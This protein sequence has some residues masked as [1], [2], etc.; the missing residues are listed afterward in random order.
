[1]IGMSLAVQVAAALPGPRLAVGLGGARL[2]D[3]EDGGA[4]HPL[5]VPWLVAVGPGLTVA[6]IVGIGEV[7]AR[8]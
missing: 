5:R 3:A 6:P 8:V 4:C 1:M 2:L 7:A